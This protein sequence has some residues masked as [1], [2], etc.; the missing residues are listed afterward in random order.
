MMNKTSQAYLEKIKAKLEKEM[1][2]NN[3]MIEAE[4]QKKALGAKSDQD[5]KPN[6]RFKNFNDVFSGLTRSKQVKTQDPMISCIISYNSRSAITITKKSDRVHYVHQFSL[7]TCEMTFMEKYG[8]RKDEFGEDISYI[9]CNEIEQNVS[10]TQF[11]CCYLDDGHFFCRLFGEMNRTAEEIKDNEL[12]INEALGLNNH[13]M[14]INNFPDPFIDCC[15]INDDLLFINLFHNK[16][17]EHHHFFYY[18][19]E[20]RIVR[21]TKLSMKGLS[22]PKNFPTKCFYNTEYNEI[23]TFYRQG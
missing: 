16:L 21:H 23:Y 5:V 12:D 14:P 6:K 11:A 19:K 3:L 22:S 17:V 4:K 2:H 7:E 13:T 1:L 18:W 20:K 9:K 15:F 8:G 10:G